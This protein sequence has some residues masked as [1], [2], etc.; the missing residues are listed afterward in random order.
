MNIILGSLLFLILAQAAGPTVFPDADRG[1]LDGIFAQA[2]RGNL[3]ALPPG[4]VVAAV[5]KGFLGADYA[6]NPLEKEG[7]ERLIIRLSRFD[8]YTL[9]EGS[10]V[11][12]G[13]IKAGRL[14]EEDFLKETANVRYRDGTIRGY[15]SRLH[16]FS[17][18]IRELERRGRGRDITRSL[19]G[20]P[21][22][23]KIS[24][25]SDNPDKYPP[26]KRNRSYLEELRKIEAEISLW[27]KYHIPKELVDK[28]EGDI[29]NGDL[30]GITTDIKGLDISHAGIAV[31]GEGGRLHLL[32]APGP[33]RQVE[34]TASPLADYLAAN[35]RQTGIMVFR[36]NG[37]KSLNLKSLNLTIPSSKPHQRA[38]LSSLKI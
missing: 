8:C 1:I 29:R 26:L 37:V 21:Y 4:E 23:K 2:R 7:E 13:L 11:L 17:D 5:G 6:A 19:G 28:T 24:Y 14:T 35:K 32:H 38:E 3:A 9:V 10:L 33:G 16:Y 36:S 15:P 30:I 12:A 34:I 25:M 20:I 27:R 22:Q 18:W 31:R